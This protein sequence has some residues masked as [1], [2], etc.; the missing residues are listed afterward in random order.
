MPILLVVQVATGSTT[1]TIFKRRCRNCRRGTQP[2]V[3]DTII[4][5]GYDPESVNDG[6]AVGSIRPGNPELNESSLAIA[7]KS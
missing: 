5:T 2:I 7:S 3:L 6:S 4:S 1:L